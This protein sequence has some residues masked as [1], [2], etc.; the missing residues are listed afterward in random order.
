VIVAG[1]EIEAAVRP[2]TTDADADALER[3]RLIRDLAEA[4]GWLAA[5]RERLANHSFVSRAPA[6]VV[7]AA[8]VREAELSDQVT[9]LRDRL[10]R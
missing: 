10:E 2:K 1:G 3:D 9:R 5:A 8:R 7:E 6:A 4:E